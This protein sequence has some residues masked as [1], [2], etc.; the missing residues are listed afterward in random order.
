M[1]S[2]IKGINLTHVLRNDLGFFSQDFSVQIVCTCITQNFEMRSNLNISWTQEDRPWILHTSI[3]WSYE[4]ILIQGYLIQAEPSLTLV[5]QSTLQDPWDPVP[6]SAASLASVWCRTDGAPSLYDVSH[7]HL[8]SQ[9]SLRRMRNSGTNKPTK[10]L[11]SYYYL[12]TLHV[13]IWT[14][15]LRMCQVKWR[16][17]LN[18][19]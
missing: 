18:W 4:V 12:F 3:L 10:S 11:T 13:K 9:K 17:Q 7:I 15:I 14:R 8:L 2:V 5:L 19:H 16:I 6:P 1:C